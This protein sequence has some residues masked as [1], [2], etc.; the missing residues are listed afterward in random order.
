MINLVLE[1]S[2]KISIEYNILCQLFSNSEYI[3][4]PEVTILTQRKK[5]HHKCF[6]SAMET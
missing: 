6:H 4:F 5:T 3:L 1:E 2:L